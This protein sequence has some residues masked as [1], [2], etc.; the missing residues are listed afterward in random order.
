MA[1]TFRDLTNMD[2]MVQY[3]E[4]YKDR[5]LKEELAY[6]MNYVKSGYIRKDDVA[7]LRWLAF[8]AYKRI[9]ELED[10]LEEIKA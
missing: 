1:R 6:T 4:K 7:Y 8:T 2:L 9:V 3:C 10:E 5:D